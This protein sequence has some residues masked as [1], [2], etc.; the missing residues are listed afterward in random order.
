MKKT[1]HNF[2]V[3]AICFCLD[4]AEIIFVVAMAIIL[5]LIGLGYRRLF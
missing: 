1:L 5:A 3:R 4:N 2:M